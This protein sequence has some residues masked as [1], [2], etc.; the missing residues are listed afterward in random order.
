MRCH[1]CGNKATGR[2]ER[3]GNP[4]CYK[5]G[6]GLCHN[7]IPKVG[8]LSSALLF[9]GILAGLVLVIAFTGWV[10]YWGPQSQ[11]VPAENIATPA[12]APASTATP[13]RVVAVTTPT[14][15]AVPVS[16]TPTPAPTP[17]ASTPQSYTVK[18]G[19]TLSGIAEK[20]GASTADIMRANNLKE[21]SLLQIGQVLQIPSP[22]S[23]TATPAQPSQFTPTPANYTTYTVK[24]G[25]TI[26]GIASSFGMT[27]QDIVSLNGL[28]SPDKLQIGQTLKIPSR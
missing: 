17:T 4:Y 28:D 21:T 18:A 13:A 3:C 20:V 25:D 8:L 1:T 19:D 6:D 27:M 22:L 2:C 14:I 23:A 26:S 11:E 10:F 15:A 16:A 7:C 5:H 12:T 24:N 9:R